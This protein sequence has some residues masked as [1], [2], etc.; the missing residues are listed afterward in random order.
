MAKRFP[1]TAFIGLTKSLQTEWT[2]LQ[3]IQPGI[4]EHFRPI[5]DALANNFIPALFGDTES[6]NAQA[7]R[8]LIA[9]PCRFGGLGIPDPC[10]TAERQLANSM[11][12]TQPLTDSL[13]A[14][15]DLP[16]ANYLDHA[17]DVT[18][19]AKKR[20]KEEL[21]A[22]LEAYVHGKGRYQQRRIKRSQDCGSWL[23]TMP[24]RLNGTELSP[25]EFRDGLHL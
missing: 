24:S 10:T 16:I 1:Q 11:E 20:R 8:D 9:L 5:E 2:Y 18:T 22:E 4:E 23:T 14:R 6:T 21:T 13:L 7:L 25:T 3:R 12:L 19:A 15:T 17:R